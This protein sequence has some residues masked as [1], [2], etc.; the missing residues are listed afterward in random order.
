MRT[1]GTRL[2]SKAGSHNYH[3]ECALYSKLVRGTL[4]SLPPRDCALICWTWLLVS[5]RDAKHHYCNRGC[6]AV[7][8][9]QAPI[10][11]QIF[12]VDMPLD[13]CLYQGWYSYY[14][15]ILNIKLCTHTRNAIPWYNPASQYTWI[16]TSVWL[17][18]IKVLYFVLCMTLCLPCI[19][20]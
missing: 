13:L 4:K 6:I 2:E 20:L 10:H 7:A 9:E 18:C 11:A 3:S 8:S 17:V 15:V 1:L 16:P 12:K 5:Y 14:T 19:V